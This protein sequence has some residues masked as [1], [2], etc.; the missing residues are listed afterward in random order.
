MKLLLLPIL[1]LVATLVGCSTVNSRIQEKSAYFNTLDPQ[2]QARIR[3]SV[4]HIGDT[5][6]MVYIA[7]GR[8]DRVREK[9]SGKGQESTWIYNTYWDE[10]E[11][12]HFIG[13]RRHAFFDPRLNA[14]RIY[15]EPM[16]ADFYQ[17][18]VEEYMRVMFKDGKVT[19][20]EQQTH[21]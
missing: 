20:I 4:V 5:T 1:C 10:Y 16:H 18:R 14:W 9:A 7:L 3:Q 13:Y 8:P 11:G 2:T 12:S 19:T 21:R 6:D 17:E 15:Y